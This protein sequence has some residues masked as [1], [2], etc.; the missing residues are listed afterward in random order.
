FFDDGR[1]FVRHSPGTYDLVVSEPSNLWISGVANLFTME[2]F[3]SVKSKLR[4]GGVICQ[5][6]HLY[7]IS[8][9]DIFIFLKTFHAV[10]P[11]LS[12]WVDEGDLIVL[13]SDAPISIDAAR[14]EASTVSPNLRKS[15]ERCNLTTENILKR[16]YCDERITNSLP[17][18]SPSTPMIIQCWNFLQ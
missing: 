5:W 13:G 9:N 11:H 3:K 7:Q 17:Q 18:R 15:L 10:F 1:N 16:F 6:I 8:E 2:F 4:P 14:I 12:V